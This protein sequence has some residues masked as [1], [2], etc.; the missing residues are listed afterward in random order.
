MDKK[1]DSSKP[2]ALPSKKLMTAMFDCPED[3]LIEWKEYGEG[4][5]I[6][7]TILEGNFD[8][9]SIHEFN[10]E[11]KRW[12]FNQ[13]IAILP[14]PLTNGY[15]V[16]TSDVATGKNLS[17]FSSEKTEYE[18]VLVVCETFLAESEALI[19]TEEKALLKRSPAGTKVWMKV[20]KEKG[21]WLLLVEAAWR[22]DSYYVVNNEYAEVRKFFYD[23][24]FIWSKAGGEWKKSFTAMF[25]NPAESYMVD[26]EYTE[27]KQFFDLNG[28]IYAEYGAGVQKIGNPDFSMPA[29]NYMTSP[30]VGAERFE[31]I[32]SVKE[33][34]IGLTFFW[35][36][37]KM[38]INGGAV[39]ITNYMTSVIADAHGY[40]NGGWTRIESS[41]TTFDNI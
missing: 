5:S 20:D 6:E 11:M 7:Y 16:Y 17:F 32:E 2:M 14:A 12:A 30:G 27:T 28:Y 8:V 13:G 18:A 3:N 26:D 41:K 38:D 10:Y 35:K 34:K 24:D 1:T 40:S 36:W 4:K 25:F 31:K 33:E 9:I 39:I 15:E 23:H 29:E 19:H 21:G 22:E 37:K